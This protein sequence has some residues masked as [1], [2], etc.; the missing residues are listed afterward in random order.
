MNK[1]PGTN[2]KK[3]R[4]KTGSD[5]KNPANAE[6]QHLQPHEINKF[7]L[8]LSQNFSFAKNNIFFCK[9]YFYFDICKILK[10]WI[11]R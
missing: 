4:N 7:V 6:I 8:V 9:L 5:S 1:T 10:S 3:G 2:K 11:F